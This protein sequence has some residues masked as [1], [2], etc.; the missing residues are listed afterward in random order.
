MVKA[1][2]FFKDGTTRQ[3][4][5]SSKWWGYLKMQVEQGHIL[6]VWDIDGFEFRIADVQHVMEVA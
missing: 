1:K 6:E 3:A 2:I 4:L 5:L